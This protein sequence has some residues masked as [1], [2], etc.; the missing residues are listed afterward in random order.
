MDSYDPCIDVYGNGRTLMKYDVK[1]R[2]NQVTIQN[3]GA[4]VGETAR[5]GRITDNRRRCFAGDPIDGRSLTDFVV[6]S[7]QRNRITDLARA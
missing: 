1:E 3:S 2:M 4:F 6:A 7:A 5:L